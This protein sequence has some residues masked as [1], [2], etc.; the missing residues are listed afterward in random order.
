M[1][2]NGKISAV[3]T[4]AWNCR[5]L[6]GCALGVCA[7]KETVANGVH[8][9]P[10]LVLVPV[11]DDYVVYQAQSRQLRFDVVGLIGLLTWP[12]AKFSVKRSTFRNCHVIGK[13]YGL[14][15]TGTGLHCS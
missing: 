8:L 4:V 9:T 5:V 14:R 11:L 3:L 15:R 2:E 12:L 1:D 7:F 6:L 10:R 13:S